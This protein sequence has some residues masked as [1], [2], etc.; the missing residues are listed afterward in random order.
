MRRGATINSLL[1]S[2]DNA[3]EE[4][5][6]KGSAFSSREPL[7][8]A[9]KHWISVAPAAPLSWLRETCS[10]LAMLDE[11]PPFRTREEG[12]EFQADATSI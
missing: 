9:P 1:Y 3:D 8:E 7:S 10:I 2:G 6:A 4:R 11:Y 5:E 12:R